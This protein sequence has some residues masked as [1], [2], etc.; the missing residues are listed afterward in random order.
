MRRCLD[1]ASRE[2]ASPTKCGKNIVV[3]CWAIDQGGG[4]RRAGICGLFSSQEKTAK[5]PAAHAIFC[6]WLSGLNAKQEMLLLLADEVRPCL[7]SDE[8]S[9]VGRQ[10]VSC[11]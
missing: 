1:K 3:A 2:Q 11:L 8:F 7:V 10:S 9:E 5:R 6:L 4:K